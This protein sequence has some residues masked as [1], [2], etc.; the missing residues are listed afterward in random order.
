MTVQEAFAELQALDLKN[1]GAWPR[2]AHIGAAVMA[3]IVLVGFGVWTFLKP[4]YETLG[5]EEQTEQ[6][7]RAEFEKKQQK[8]AA[9]DAY[10]AQLETMERDFGAMLR[11]LPSKTE[12]ENLLNDISQTRVASSLEEELFQP[13]TEIPKDFYAE[14]P[15]RIV[16]TGSYHQMGAFVGGVAALPRIV[17]IDE[18][19]IKPAGG[20]AQQGLGRGALRM[21]AL[22]KTYRYL[23]ES[24]I[25]ATDPAA[26]RA[27]RRGARQ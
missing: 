19:E 10:K 6:T 1:P 4:E 3:F 24:E 8:V 12:V 13:Q 22:A 9:L 14:V 20:T 17:T 18:V 16:V 7:L 11:Q 15:N 27:G 25:T 23:D 26:G 21:S 2:W 5:V